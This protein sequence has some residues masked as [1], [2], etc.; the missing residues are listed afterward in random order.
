MENERFALH[1]GRKRPAYTPKDI[2]CPSCGAGLT[3]KDERS[4]LVVCEYCGSHLDVSQ[5]EKQVLGKGTGRKWNFPLHLGDSFRWK[6]ARYEIIARL[7]FIEDGD[8]DEASRQYLLY[9]PYHGTLWLDEYDGHYSLSSD[10]HVMPTEDAFR[11]RR[12]DVLTTYDKQQWVM[13]GSGTYELVY[14]D[15]A[16]PWIAAIG[17]QIQYAE[18][19]NNKSPKL[20]YEVQRIGNE[21]EYGKGESLSLAQVRRALE[22]PEFAKEQ[23]AAVPVENVAETRQTYIRLMAI[24]IVILVVNVALFVYT[25]SRGK[26]ALQQQFSSQELTQETLSKPFTVDKAGDLV[27]I[28]AEA[29]LSNA[30]MALDLGV[31]WDKESLIHVDEADI[32]YYYGSDGGESWSEGSRKKSIYVKLPWEGTYQLLVHA[33]SASGNAQSAS[34]AMHNATIRVYTG[35]LMPQYFLFIGF[36]ALV[37]LAVLFIMYNNWKNTGGGD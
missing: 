24:V 23:T 1:S 20:Q 36:L 25:S 16:L 22:K 34:Q 30:W 33:V 28:T 27:K 31:V 14:V 21:I 15:G 6:K 26:L 35:A 13:E 18:F 5:E 37:A 7:V 2:H 9:N 4:E 32:S 10:S 12:G 3:V 8:D 29:G 11:K 19:V 17:D